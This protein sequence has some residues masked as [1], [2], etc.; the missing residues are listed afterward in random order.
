MSTIVKIVKDFGLD[1]RLAHKHGDS[2][3]HPA[4]REHKGGDGTRAYDANSHE[5]HDAKNPTNAKEVLTNAELRKAYADCLQGI[6]QPEFAKKWE[7]RKLA[8][9]A[10]RAEA[11]S[12]MTSS[13]EEEEEEEEKE[14]AQAGNSR[15]TS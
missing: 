1:G 7:E 8:M 11:K 10:K 12:A 3:W 14:L 2:D 9:K 6:E 5:V 15:Q 13:E 4:H